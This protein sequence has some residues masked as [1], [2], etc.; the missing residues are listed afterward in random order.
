MRWGCFF[1]VGTNAGQVY[2]R[3][4]Q[5]PSIGRIETEKSYKA[6]APRFNFSFMTKEND[7]FVLNKLAHIKF[8]MSLAKSQKSR[9][10][11]LRLP[12]H[13]GSKYLIYAY[14]DCVCVVYS[15][16]KSPLLIPISIFRL[17][18]KCGYT[19]IWNIWRMKPEGLICSDI[20][21]SAQADAFPNSNVSWWQED[22][23]IPL[24]AWS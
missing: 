1:E 2:L 20:Y 21:L 19:N 24:V 3:H 6:T 10:T 16:E 14:L 11:I 5:F 13:R 9:S 4:K 17:K 12:N 7:L 18:V 22:T 8:P 23:C 15:A